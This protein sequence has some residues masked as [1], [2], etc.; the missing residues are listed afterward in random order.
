MSVTTNIAVLLDVV[1]CRLLNPQGLNL[2]L[3]IPPF[4]PALHVAYPHIFRA[5]SL[6]PML[7][8]TGNGSANVSNKKAY[9]DG[10]VQIQRKLIFAF[11]SIIYI[12]C[13]KWTYD[14]EVV[15]ILFDGLHVSPPKL[16]NKIRL[17][18]VLVFYIQR[19]LGE[20]HC[21]SY[22]SKIP[23]NIIY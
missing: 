17:I 1:S 20:L 9:A 10:A 3:Y 4:A 7:R 14:W 5:T 23:L 21:C 11:L 16:L 8:L 13:I 18:L 15:A 6:P 2:L 19:E 22:R 12:K